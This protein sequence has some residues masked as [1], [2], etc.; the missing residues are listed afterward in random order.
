MTPEFGDA[1]DLI[2]LQES[3][4]LALNGQFDVF[5][6]LT[7]RAQ[8]LPQ[9]VSVTPSK[10]LEIKG[11]SNSAT[12]I[13]VRAHDAPGFLSKIAHVISE[14]GVDIQAAIVETLGSEVVDVFYVN[15]PTGEILSDMRCQQLI[16]ALDY[17]CN[18]VS[19]TI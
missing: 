10:I 16:Q 8:Y 13:E 1:P 7:L 4:R 12:V 11:V 18:H 9:P 15:E 5:E 6:K 14:N 19:A 17:A 3:L 2:Q